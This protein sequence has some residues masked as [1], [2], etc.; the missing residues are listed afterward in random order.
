MLP[1]SEML[2]PYR[3][4]L[5]LLRS[6][7]WQKFC[8]AY[9]NMIIEEVL[10]NGKRNQTNGLDQLVTLATENS[11]R[12]EEV[13]ATMFDPSSHIAARAAW[14]VRRVAERNSDVLDAHKDYIIDHLGQPMIWEVQAELCHVLPVLHLDRD[15]LDEVMRFFESGLQQDSRIVITW[16]LNG[17]YELSKQKSEF[18][19][20]AAELTAEALESPYASVRARARAIHKALPKLPEQS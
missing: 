17:I 4:S 13:I 3:V 16:S 9:L 1:A 6:A 11:Y 5:L 12:L 19:K 8:C 2:M 20:R 10:D 14:V 7:M 18:R 15:E